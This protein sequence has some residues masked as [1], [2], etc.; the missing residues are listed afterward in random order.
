MRDNSRCTFSLEEELLWIMNSYF[1]QKCWICFSFCLLQ[2]LTDG[3]ECCGLLWCFY[4]LSFWR[5]P[6]TTEH[7]LLRHWRRDTFLMKKHT[8]MNWGWTHSQCFWVNYSFKCSESVTWFTCRCFFI[9]LNTRSAAERLI[10]Q[11]RSTITLTRAPS[12]L[13]DETTILRHSTHSITCVFSLNTDS[14]HT[15]FLL[16]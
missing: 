3:L 4:Q 13:W 15:L 12:A 9:N 1:S 11:S 6:F 14:Q 10:F 7:P 8:Q 16:L 2:M 5:H